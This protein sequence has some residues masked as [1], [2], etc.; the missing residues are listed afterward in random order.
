[1]SPF[2]F[3]GLEDVELRHRQ[4]PRTFSSRLASCEVIGNEQRYLKIAAQ[5][6]ALNFSRMQVA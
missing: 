5:E 6:Q 4:N 3:V 2:R 1:M